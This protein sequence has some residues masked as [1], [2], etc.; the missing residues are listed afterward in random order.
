MDEKGHKLADAD[1]AV[2][3][4]KAALL[5]TPNRI[6]KFGAGGLADTDSSIQEDTTG[7]LG[8]GTAPSA[9][10]PLLFNGDLNPSLK[11][12]YRRWSCNQNTAARA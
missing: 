8:F 10:T 9:T 4:A 6:A 12:A 11:Q 3:Q 7:K 1:K 2:K 5:G